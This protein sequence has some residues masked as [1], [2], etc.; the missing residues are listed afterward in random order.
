MPRVDNDPWLSNDD[1]LGVSVDFSN[2]GQEDFLAAVAQSNNEEEAAEPETPSG[3]EPTWNDALPESGELSPEV[4][5][6]VPAPGQERPAQPEVAAPPAVEHEPQEYSYEDGSSVVVEKTSKGWKA[7]L[8]SGV[9]GAKKEV[10]YGKTKDELFANV[11]VGKINAT[12]K[13]RE[14]SQRTR[15][16]APAVQ[17]A[18]APAQPVATERELTAD[19]Q[20][21]LKTMFADNPANAID[22]FLKLKTGHN[23]TE[24]ARLAQEGREAGQAARL[25][26]DSESVAKAFIAANP[27]Y[28]ADDESQNYATI[29]AWILR[30][31]MRPAQPFIGIDAA[32]ETI[33]QAG[34]WNTEILQEAFDAL[35][36]D[37]LLLEKPAEEVETPAPAA[38]APTPAPTSRIA[39]T[40]T[41]R[42]AA[43]ANYGLH[44]RDASALPAIPD[45]N[46][47]P[48]VEE[49]E[50]LSNDEIANLF[51]GVVRLNARQKARRS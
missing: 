31:K 46:R 3:G 25:E 8:D 14:L 34:L 41:G 36:E 39:E 42:R 2:R 50:E 38:A 1:G 33:I 37:G 18:P 27:D 23:A 30:Y 6:N 48:S 12:R 9:S 21:Q 19:E 47:A 43:P 13:I 7:T 17:P 5:S 22:H 10:F 11:A 49:L 45:A 20:F 26:V 16:A 51:S 40:R 44:N 28:Y 35:S 24:L 4:V 32:M 15:Q 29:L